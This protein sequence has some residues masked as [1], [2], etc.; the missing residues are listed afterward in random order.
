MNIKL[1]FLLLLVPI[2]L[3]AQ[4][5]FLERDKQTHMIIGYAAATTC[6]IA[7]KQWG[8]QN[9]QGEDANKY[10]RA[11]FC[12]LGSVFI[13]ALIEAGQAWGGQGAEANDIA[14]TALG[15]AMAGLVTITIDF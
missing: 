6:N 8:T 2:N 3:C 5:F 13:G 7:L 1:L 11:W 4:N 15:G 9:V 14:A 10:E 12:T